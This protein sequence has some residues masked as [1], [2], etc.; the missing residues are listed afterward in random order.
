[1][2]PDV[3]DGPDAPGQA[4]TI[5]AILCRCS[6]GGT[7]CVNSCS[8]LSSPLSSVALPC[9]WF[10]PPLMPHAVMATPMMPM[11]AVAANN[12]KKGGC[13][14]IRCLPVVSETKLVFF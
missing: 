11:G 14:T 8:E 1:M 6:Q 5:D 3:L 7:K 2:S 4:A 9:R 12:T 10:P 13:E